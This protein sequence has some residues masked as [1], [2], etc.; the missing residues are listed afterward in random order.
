MGSQESSPV[1]QFESINSSAF[2]IVQ[3]MVTCFLETS[4]RILQDSYV[5]GDAI[6]FL[7]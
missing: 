4:F 1:P 3:Q 6:N 7:I 2:F 5:Y